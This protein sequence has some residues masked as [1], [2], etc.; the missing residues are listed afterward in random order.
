MISA[1]F[2][3]VLCVSAVNRLNLRSKENVTHVPDEDLQ[4]LEA[5]LDDELST[6]EVDAL[7]GR[8]IEDPALASALAD[9]REARSV[10][11]RV[12]AIMEPGELAITDAVA[13]VQG[14]IRNRLR[15]QNRIRESLRYAA[16]AACL[17]IGVTIGSRYAAPSGQSPYQL[18]DGTPVALSGFGSV[19]GGSSVTSAP[20]DGESQ[21]RLVLGEDPGPAAPVRFEPLTPRTVVLKDIH[22]R[23]IAATEFASAVEARQFIE[24]LRQAAAASGRSLIPLGPVQLPSRDLVGVPVAPPSNLDAPPPI[25]PASATGAVGARF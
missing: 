12:F 14:S 2:L 10:R 15:W 20:N 4:L 23:I 8:L 17:V 7:R 1:S 6:D 16:A 11:Q 18:P 13:G 25:V 22:G 5:Y 19:R 9:L 21:D 3:R 24:E